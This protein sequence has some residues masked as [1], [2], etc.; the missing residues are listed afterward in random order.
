M[1]TRTRRVEHERPQVL[2]QYRWK[3]Y[4]KAPENPS[5]NTAKDDSTKDMAQDRDPAKKDAKLEK[6]NQGKGKSKG[7]DKMAKTPDEMEKAELLR[8]LRWEHPVVTLDVGTLKANVRRAQQGKE[9]L[10]TEVM[11]CLKEAVRLAADTKRSCQRLI[12]R[13][14]ECIMAPGVFQEADREFLD[15]ICPRISKEML[16]NDEGEKQE[17][18]DEDKSA[19]GLFIGM[20]LRYLLSDVQSRDTTVIGKRMARF[21]TRVRSLGLLSGKRTLKP[22][23]PGSLLL[24]SV[25]R[26]L[27]RELKKTYIHGSKALQDEVRKL[28]R[29]M[30]AQVSQP[31]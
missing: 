19:Q 15:H 22:N 2:K 12:G 13:F 20:L 11:R 7:K 16:Y 5:E 27:C 8:A 23:Y 25:G 18:D 21:L 6:S 24:E 3:P 31:Y 17:P 28:S 4:R 29:N 9:D 26:E 30:A 10:S 14:I 1:R